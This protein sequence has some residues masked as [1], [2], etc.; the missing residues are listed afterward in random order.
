[1]TSL[2]QVVRE[3]ALS[4]NAQG[5]ALGQESLD[6]LL[7]PCGDQRPDV[8]VRPGRPPHHQRV[9]GCAHARGN[10][11]INTALDQHTGAGR[12]GLARILDASADQEGQGSLKV[13]VVKHQLGGRL[14]AQLQRHGHHVGGRSCLHQ[15]TYANRPSE[16]DMVDIRMGRQR[17]A[18][19]FS[20]PGHHV[21]RTGG[22]SPASSARATK[23]SAVRQASSA[24]FSTQ[25]LPIA[26]AA[27]PTDR[28][29]ICIG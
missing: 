20:K 7:L 23:A 8:Q 25:A 15:S 1:M 3:L 9:I 17:R 5:V 2:G 16:R 6:N 11:V 4:S 19:L 29:M 14:A 26:K 13:R 10:L 22:G 18:G 12:T 27:P 28:P 21:Q 24:G